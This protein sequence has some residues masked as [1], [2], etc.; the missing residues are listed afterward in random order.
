MPRKIGFN[1]LN[2]WLKLAAI[3]GWISLLSFIAGFIVGLL[4]PY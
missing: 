1:N 2:T 4:T 3:G